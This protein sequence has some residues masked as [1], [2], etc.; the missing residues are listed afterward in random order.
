M[1][2][3]VIPLAQVARVVHA[4][5]LTLQSHA[6]AAVHVP[7]T[8]IAAPITRIAIVLSFPAVLTIRMACIPLD[9]GAIQAASS[10]E[11]VALTRSS[12]PTLPDP[13]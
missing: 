12:P 9:A 13:S 4:T 1:P 10:S 8:V 3:M 11:I 5:G 2:I 7:S 6:S